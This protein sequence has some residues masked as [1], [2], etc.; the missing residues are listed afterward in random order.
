MRE[1]FFYLTL[2]SVAWILDFRRIWRVQTVP[3]WDLFLAIFFIVSIGYSFVLQR[4]KVVVTL[5]AIYVGI[6]MANVLGEP[7]GSIFN[8]DKEVADQLFI[9]ANASPFT[10]QAAIFFLTVILVTIRSGLGVGSSRRSSL[11]AFELAIFSFLNSALIL[12][13]VFSFMAPEAQAQMSE[14][15]RIAK[16]IIGRETWWMLAPLIALVATG[17][18]GKSRSSSDY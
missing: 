13:A 3:S 5:L 12:S 18:L 10:V 6:V 9:R 14:T 2:A 1:V 8:G 16:A 15:S 17:G 4:D 11:S 7:I